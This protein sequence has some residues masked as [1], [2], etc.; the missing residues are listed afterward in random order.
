MATAVV[1]RCGDCGH[2]WETTTLRLKLDPIHQC[3]KCRFFATPEVQRGRRVRNDNR[4][5]SLAQEKKAEQRYGARRQPASG[6]MPH[7]KSDLRDSGRIRVECK[8]T[9]AKSFTL[10]LEELKKLEREKTGDEH[11][12]FEIEFQAEKPFKRYVVIPQWLYSHLVG[13]GE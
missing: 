3:P 11:P 13:E 9:R 6:A 7:S 2:V 4:E 10:K 1:A 8:F 12:V 5:R